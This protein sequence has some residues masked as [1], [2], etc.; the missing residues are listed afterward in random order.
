MRFAPFIFPELVPDQT[1]S[2]KPD[3][4]TNME[5][6]IPLQELGSVA[7]KE[8]TGVGFTVTLNNKG[9]LAHPFKVAVAET[10]PVI[11][12][13]VLLLAKLNGVICPVPEVPRPIDVLELFQVN[14][15]PAGTLTKSVG[16][17]NEPGQ[18]LTSLIG[19][20]VGVGRIVIV[21]DELDPAQPFKV[22]VTVTV[23]VTFAFDV[24]T[25]AL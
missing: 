21:K 2:P 16:S 7:V 17:T 10:V 8:I 4:E 23:P 5:P 6:S 22:G 18:P 11:A 3:P 1:T 25:G 24:F 12:L 19:L 13:E 14:E 20:I 15:A 9:T